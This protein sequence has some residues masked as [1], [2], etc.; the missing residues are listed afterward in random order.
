MSVINYLA[1]RQSVKKVLNDAET[2]LM[3]VCDYCK[4]SKKC[5]RFYSIKTEIEKKT[6]FWHLTNML[7]IGI[8]EIQNLMKPIENLKLDLLEIQHLECKMTKLLHN[9]IKESL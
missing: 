3:K 5:K 1:E 6:V 9:D 2:A 4:N 8:L 7:N